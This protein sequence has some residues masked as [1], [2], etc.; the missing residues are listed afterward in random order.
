M[1][2]AGTGCDATGR[3]R[4][5]SPRETAPGATPRTRDARRPALAGR[6]PVYRFRFRGRRRPRRERL[7][8]DVPDERAP[9]REDRPGAAA[10]GV[11]DELGERADLVDGL[12][13]EPDR[14][15]RAG[16]GS[17][18]VTP[19]LDTAVTGVLAA[20]AGEPVGR[21]R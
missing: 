4:H 1:T 17:A 16:H 18:V 15:V 9:V 21:S 13:G 20:L 14:A 11:G 5:R 2:A 6:P 8:L 12:V 3:R 7:G 19:S 10:R